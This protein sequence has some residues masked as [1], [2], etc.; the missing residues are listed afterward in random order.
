MSA[1][2]ADGVEVSPERSSWV[3]HVMSLALLCLPVS[4]ITTMSASFLAARSRTVRHLQYSWMP[5]PAL[6]QVMVTFVW[7]VE[8][9]SPVKMGHGEVTVFTPGGGGGGQS[10]DVCRK[11]YENHAV[12]MTPAALC[13]SAADG[14]EAAVTR[15]GR[16]SMIMVKRNTLGG[17]VILRGDD[18]HLLW[19]M[20]NVGE[21]CLA[22]VQGWLRDGGVLLTMY[23]G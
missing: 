22:S 15:C 9:G 18:A 10:S 7:L 14:F 21:V 2:L 12:A 11:R 17:G 8:I 4:D 16:S 6:M 23:V 5:P 20:D 3:C 13:R 19:V 1:C